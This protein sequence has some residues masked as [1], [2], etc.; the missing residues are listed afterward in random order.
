M[1]GRLLYNGVEIAKVYNVTPDTESVRITSKALDGTIYVQ[2]IGDHTRKLITEIYAGS[3]E[4]KLLLNEAYDYGAIVT[5]EK[6]GS[7]YYGVIENAI[8]WQVYGNQFT[9]QIVLLLEVG[10]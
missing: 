5:A 8:T 7:T 1:I 4:D 6:D 10:V 9:A 2:S 3:T